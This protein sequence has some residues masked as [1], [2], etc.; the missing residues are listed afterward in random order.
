MKEPGTQ[1]EVLTF[2]IANALRLDDEHLEALVQ[3]LS[4]AWSNRKEKKK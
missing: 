2:L 1:S 3:S 4:K